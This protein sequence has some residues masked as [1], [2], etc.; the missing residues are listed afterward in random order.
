MVS[1]ASQGPLRQL[2][3]ARRSFVSLSTWVCAEDNPETTRV[4]GWGRKSRWA[5]VRHAMLVDL[6]LDLPPIV[7][8][9]D[10]LDDP[11]DVIDA[12]LLGPFIAG[13]Q[14]VS[15][16]TRLE[17]V[18]ADARLLP[19]G[20]TP[21]R[22]ATGGNRRSLLA[23]GAGWTLRSVRWN[24]A[25]ATVTVVAETDELAASVLAEA[26][27][28]ACNPL[29]QDGP[30]PIAFWHRT[31]DGRARRSSR[32][33][34]AVHWPDIRANYPGVAARALE[35][36]MAIGPGDAIGRL[37]LLH[38]PPGTGKTTA[39]RA[40]AATWRD[41][42]RAEVVVDSDRLYGDAAYLMAVL[43][44]HDDERDPD[45]QA[46]WRLLILEDCDELIRADAKKE[47]GQA[48]GRLLNVT[49][50]IIGEGLR[51]LVAITTNEP[52]GTLHPAIVR[53]GRCLAEIHIDRLSRAE[54]MAWLGSG[55]AVAADG[56]TLAELYEL[57]AARKSVRARE[58]RSVTG[59]YL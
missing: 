1:G 4:S 19:P 3:T 10:D 51:L 27:D 47:A 14:P 45:G 54:A 35:R 9:L 20:V 33:L 49:D 40:I 34:T 17:R 37:L 30:I 29:A 57:R 50:G 13:R 2:A 6:P 56:A 21:C 44:G 48:L 8:T 59:M 12:V 28:G 5:A 18:R 32:D 36:V 58:L 43:L 23:E 55:G 39:L 15:H 38:G 26:V 7:V 41:W 46:R 22:V 53:P 52:L 31:C 24:D 42:C 11:A 25:C 16:S